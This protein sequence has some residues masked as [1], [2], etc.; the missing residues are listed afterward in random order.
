[1]DLFSEFYYIIYIIERDE[2]MPAFIGR[3]TVLHTPTTNKVKIT[4]QQAGRVIILKISDV[5][6]GYYIDGYLFKYRRTITILEQSGSDLTD[7]QVCIDLNAANFDFSHFLNEGKDLRFTDASGNLLD[8]WVESM[9]IAAQQATIWVKV[10]SIPA[11]STVDIYMYYGNSEANSVSN[12]EATFAFFDDFNITNAVSTNGGNGAVVDAYV[13]PQA[14]YHNEKV[15][16]TYQGPDLDIY[17]V[18]YNS[19]GTIEGPYFVADNPLTNDAHGAPAIWVD[20]DGYYHIT[21]GSHASAQKH[22]KS[23]NPGGISSWEALPDITSSATYPQVIKL[24]GVLYL[25]YRAGGHTSDWVYRTSTDGGYT[26]SGETVIIDSTAENV[27]YVSF[28]K[29]KDGRIHVAW[30]WKDESNLLGT[31]EP[32]YYQRYNVYYM[33]RDHDGNW[34]N[35]EGEALTLPITK[36]IAD[37][38]CLVY[39]TDNLTPLK[40]CNEAVADA[41]E[42]GTP[43]IL[44]VYSDLYGGTEYLWKVA[45]WNGSSWDIIDVTTTSCTFSCGDINVIDENNI[46]VFIPSGGVFCRQRNELGR[47]GQIEKWKSTDGGQTWSKE[48]IIARSPN[49]ELIMSEGETSKLTF[50]KSNLFNNVHKIEYGNDEF[51]IIFYSRTHFWDEH[52]RSIFI[53]GDNGF[54]GTKSQEGYVR[55]YIS[56]TRFRGAL[57]NTTYTINDNVIIETSAE[58]DN[59]LFMC[60][61]SNMQSN[62]ECYSGNIMGETYNINSIARIDYNAAYDGS[63]LEH[64]GDVPFDPELNQKYLLQ[65]IKRTDGY[66]EF[67]VN[68]NSI[69][70]TNTVYSGGNSGMG[71]Q[72]GGDSSAPG[73]I[74]FWWFRVRKYTEPEPSVTIGEEET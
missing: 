40:H 65:L 31:D 54:K 27:W 62:G 26:W 59:E 16:I 44:F 6:E 32:E 28:R 46:E 11:N 7:Y 29:G 69:N 1:M 61:I 23:A 4:V 50:S 53:W 72:A 70:A 51:K 52:D 5:S 56:S 20:A 47:G 2:K 17:V 34:K 14:I 39:R 21:Y 42:N 25:F 45:K 15:I 33:Y 63:W 13:N 38:Y 36:D 64:L 8:Y 24:D 37:S 73:N 71:F 10:P 30:V 58:M 66:I 12:A 41:T 3:K 19:D 48:R 9:D 43:F 55:A 22:V 68:G 60:V 57:Y 49:Y 67:R 35:V 18:A 74:R